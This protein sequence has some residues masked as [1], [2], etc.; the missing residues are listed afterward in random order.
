MLKRQDT[1]LNAFA[2]CPEEKPA[3]PVSHM[4][5]RNVLLRLESGHAP[6]VHPRSSAHADGGVFTAKTWTRRH[7]R[8]VEEGL[9]LLFDFRLPA[10]RRAV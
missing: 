7:I 3:F 10:K 4:V 2:G 5:G 6:C 9:R 8:D 1:K